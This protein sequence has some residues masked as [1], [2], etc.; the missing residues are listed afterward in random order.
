MRAARE[1]PVLAIDVGGTKTAVA[2]T[3]AG[4]V[5][6]F[7]AAANY[8]SADFPT[9]E[10]LL[11]VYLDA[12]PARA[13]NFAAI[14]VGAAGPVLGRRCQVTNLR[15]SIDADA[16]SDRRRCAPHVHA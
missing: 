7:S 1:A 14:G 10:A 13:G 4:D 8:A 11:D 3:T 16:I 15:W 2:T 5:R 9:L 12:H 6:R